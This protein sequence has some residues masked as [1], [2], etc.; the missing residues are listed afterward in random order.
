MKDIALPMVFA[1]S[2]GCVLFLPFFSICNTD[3][4]PPLPLIVRTMSQH[5]FI[6]VLAFSSDTYLCQL[7]S[8]LGYHLVVVERL[9]YL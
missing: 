4:L 2:L 8:P 6:D 5:F 3:G 9:V 1:L 7:S